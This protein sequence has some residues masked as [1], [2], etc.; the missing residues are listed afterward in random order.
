MRCPRRKL[1]SLVCF[2]YCSTHNFRSDITVCH[3]NY[4]FGFSACTIWCFPK[5]TLEHILPRCNLK[6]TLTGNFTNMKISQ[7]EFYAMIT[8]STTSYTLNKYSIMARDA[9]YVRPMEIGKLSACKGWLQRLLLSHS[10][11]FLSVW[12][13]SLLQQID[14]S[15]CTLL[16]FVH[17]N[18]VSFI[19]FSKVL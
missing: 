5:F 4:V 8:G 18:L 12:L 17:D 10:Y 13:S 6:V 16:W 14:F 1:T 3:C 15:Q 11:Y 19:Q 2:W 7:N 9:P